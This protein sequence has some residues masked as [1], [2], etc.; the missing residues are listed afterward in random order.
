VERAAKPT[1]QL[2]RSMYKTEIVDVKSLLTRSLTT[3]RQA[4]QRQWSVVM[5]V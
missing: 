5:E 1:E 2:M 4:R 3:C